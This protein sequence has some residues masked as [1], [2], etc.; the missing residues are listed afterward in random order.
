M[1]F[2]HPNIM[3]EYEKEIAPNLRAA[4]EEL[5]RWSILCRVPDLTVTCLLRTADSNADMY[6]SLYKRLQNGAYAATAEQEEILAEIKG[7][8]EEQLIE[9]AKGRFSWHLAG[10]AADIRSSHYTKKQLNDVVKKLH[11]I[12]FNFGYSLDEYELL[13]HDVTA[14]HIH[15]A[16]KPRKEH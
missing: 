16:F 14:P 15:F 3:G 13:V 9:K 10:R 7:L 6:M 2:K 11:R 12:A 4:L 5:D 1:I 8:N